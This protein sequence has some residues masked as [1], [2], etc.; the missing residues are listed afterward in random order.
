M[1]D[2][3]LRDTRAHENDSVNCRCSRNDVKGDASSECCHRNEEENI[4]SNNNKVRLKSSN[5]RFFKDQESPVSENSRCLLGLSILS[6]ICFCPTGIFAV[7]TAAKLQKARKVGNETLIRTL[8]SRTRMLVSMSLG[9]WIVILVFCLIIYFVN[10][11]G[12]RSY[13]T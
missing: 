6:V 1:E 5:R 12:I 13:F 4:Q 10:I 3:L 8:T 9:I 11:F 7:I 2:Q